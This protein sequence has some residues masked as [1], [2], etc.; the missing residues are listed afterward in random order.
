MASTNLTFASRE[1]HRA[2]LETQA[3]LPAGFR[4]GTTRLSFTP[5]EVAMDAKMNITLVVLDQPT[6]DF[7]GVFTRNA[8]PGAPVI[9]GRRRLAEPTVGAL[10]VNNKISNVRAPQG[11]E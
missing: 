9:V 6:P 5:A 3:V 11:V 8:F 2:W 10:V 4:V 1:A 7:A